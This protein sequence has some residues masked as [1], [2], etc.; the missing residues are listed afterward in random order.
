MLDRVVS[1]KIE[2]GFVVACFRNKTQRLETIC[3][4]K[5]VAELT[6]VAEWMIE[7]DGDR[8]RP[9]FRRSRVRV[10]YPSVRVLIDVVTRAA[11]I[12]LILPAKHEPSAI[13]N[14]R[15]VGACCWIPLVCIA[16]VVVLIDQRGNN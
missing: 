9:R 13:F 2:D 5:A 10:D 6:D 3:R 14:D 4:S 12:I 7:H 1:K 15:G 16:G 11:G 8:R